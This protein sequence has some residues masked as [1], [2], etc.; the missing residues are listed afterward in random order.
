MASSTFSSPAA[1][2]SPLSLPPPPPQASGEP[3]HMCQRRPTT[4]RDAPA[5]HDCS[6]CGT[7]VCFVCSRTCEGPRCHATLPSTNDN[8]SFQSFDNGVRP[9]KVCRRCCHEVGAEGTVWCRVCYDDDTD[10]ET[11]KGDAE[12]RQAESAGRVADWLD[13]CGGAEEADSGYTGDCE[14]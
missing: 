4:L 1:A 14:S 7:R 10:L 8:R 11:G 12:T 5:W 3:C 9:R 13:G 6:L 2:P